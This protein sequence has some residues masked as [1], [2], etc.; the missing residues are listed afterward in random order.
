MNMPNSFSVIYDSRLPPCNA[1]CPSGHDIQGW[2]AQAAQGEYRRAWEIMMDN[3]PLP[4]TM[5]RVCYHTCEGACN[6]KEFDQAVSIHALER[7]IGDLALK[8]GWQVTPATAS[9]KKILVVGAGPG[10]LS[11]AYHLARLGHSV[12]IAE[13][14]PRAGGMMAFG[15]PS[16]RLPRN[17]LD[18]EI[19]RIVNLGVTIQLDTRVDD[20]PAAIEAGGYDACF[21]AVGA[22]LAKRVD[23]STVDHTIAVIDAVAFLRAMETNPEQKKPGRKVVVYGGGNTAIDVARTVLRLGAEEVRIVYR[24]NRARMPAHR[25]E[26]EEALEEGVI[27]SDLRTI[28]HLG[29]GQ[30]CLETMAIAGDGSLQG[31]GATESIAADSLIL[32]LGQ[33]IDTVLFHA[34]P[35]IQIAKDG[36]IIVGAD[37]QTGHAGVFAGGDMISAERTVT[38]AIGHGKKAARHIDAW[39]RGTTQASTPKKDLA[40]FD[41]I[42]PMFYPRS[43]PV[44]EPRISLEARQTSFAEVVGN[45]TVRAALKEAKRC[46]SCGNCLHCDDCLNLCPDKAIRKTE[47]GGYA[48]D[49]TMCRHCGLCIAQCPC[50]MIHMGATIA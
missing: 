6:R 22:H 21:A 7:F 35:G 37:F 31:T 5:G 1:Q 47:D 49:P 38:V 15:I 26:V 19:K 8:E 33:D 4:A 45:L 9:G 10:G 46:L 12:T 25:F 17:I 43:S 2:L 50:G 30:I 29:H 32:A 3:N 16:Y 39:L 44:S 40:G 34:V 24:R 36:A 41:R 23:L 11:A 18:G 28:K 48:V 42:N 14:G 27:L 20:I 13:A